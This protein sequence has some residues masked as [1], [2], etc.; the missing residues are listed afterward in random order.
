MC[1]TPMPN[2]TARSWGV[3]L[4]DKLTQQTHLFTSSLMVHQEWKTMSSREAQGVQTEKTELVRK[5][6]LEELK[7]RGF[8]PQVWVVL[9][10]RPRA[11]FS[12]SFSG[13]QD[14]CS[15]ACSPP[16]TFSTR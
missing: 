15:R 6:C 8:S 5:I 16:L 13:S 7:A 1:S 9:V 4:G 11:M 3:H 10:D 14:R 2:S 12:N